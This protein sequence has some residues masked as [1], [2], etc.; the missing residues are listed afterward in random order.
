MFSLDSGVFSPA[1]GGNKGRVS[2]VGYIFIF[3]DCACE[4]FSMDEKVIT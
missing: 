4:V 1:N 3:E 2:V